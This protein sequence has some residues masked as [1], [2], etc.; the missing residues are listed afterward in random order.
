MPKRTQR[1]VEDKYGQLHCNCYLQG[2]AV[3]VRQVKSSMYKYRKITDKVYHCLADD[4]TCKYQV[5]FRVKTFCTWLLQGVETHTHDN[6]P[7]SGECNAE[8]K[9]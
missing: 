8:R 6:F 4:K 2:Y 1:A 3:V 7:C 9:D 5:A